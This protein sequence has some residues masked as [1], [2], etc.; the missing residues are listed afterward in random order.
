MLH[1]L[2]EL[3]ERPI[4]DIMIPRI[5]VIALD[6]NDPPGKHIEAMKARR[7]AFLPV[8]QDTIDHILGVVSVQDYMLAGAERDLRALL[9][10]PLFVPDTKR[11]DE[12][13]EAFKEREISFAVCVDEYGGTE[14]IV[15]QEDALEE[16]FGEYY[17]EYDI[18]KNP[19]RRFGSHEYLVEASI[20]LSDFND[21]FK[22]RLQSQEASTLGGYI[23]KRLGEVPQKGRVL[24]AEGFEMRIHDM[25]R[26]RIHHV[27]VRPKQ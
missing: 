16:I 2:F 8:Y 18:P 20:S 9:K 3:G 22:S 21:F 4:K 19:V 13:L 15:T 14:G 5:D 10:Q 6:V 25:I 7:F 23:L 27:M 12:V 1:K 26:T 17:D 11:I 24:E